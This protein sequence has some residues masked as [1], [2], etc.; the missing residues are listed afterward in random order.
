MDGQAICGIYPDV[1]GNRA[2]Q[3]CVSKTNYT[4]LT[5]QSILLK[6]KS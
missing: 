4:L 3:I 6:N 1:G 2:G 5:N